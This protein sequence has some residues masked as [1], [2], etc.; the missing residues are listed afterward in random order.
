MVLDDGASSASLLLNKEASE[1]YLGKD[2]EKVTDQI[3]NFGQETFVQ[4]LRSTLLGQ[5]VTVRCRCL[6]DDQGAMLLCD[7]FE[8]D[9]TAPGE[10]SQAVRASW[11]VLS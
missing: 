8:V 7:E 10:R 11:G 2:M 3:D 6:I 4:E 1:K 5:R 9:S